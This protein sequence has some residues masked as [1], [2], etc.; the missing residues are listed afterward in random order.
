MKKK[1]VLRVKRLF[2][3]V[4]EERLDIGVVKE[5]LS[6]CKELRSEEEAPKTGGVKEPPLNPVMS[7]LRDYLVRNQSS[8]SDY[9]PI[10][11]LMAT[12]TG[13]GTGKSFSVKLYKYLNLDKSYRHRTCVGAGIKIPYDKLLLKYNHR[14]SEANRI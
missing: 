6:I 11:D 4:P 1:L 8:R 2:Q 10:R 12:Y 13:G 7:S 14:V 3:L 5:M 9:H